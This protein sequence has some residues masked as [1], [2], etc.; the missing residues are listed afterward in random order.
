MWVGA[1]LKTIL[2]QTDVVMPQSV[3]LRRVHLIGAHRYDGSR[4]D[5]FFCVAVSC[6]ELCVWSV[7]PS[8]L[9]IHSDSQIRT[10]A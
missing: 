3:T 2:L 10:W 9:Q 4:Y 1:K 5:R 7:Y 6:I 8:P